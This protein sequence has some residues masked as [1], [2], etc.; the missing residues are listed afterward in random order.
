M[1]YKSICIAG[2]DGT[3]KSSTIDMIVDRLGKENVSIQYMGSRL[4]ETSKAKKYLENEP[5]SGLKKPFWIF[6]RVYAQIK[7]MYHRVRKHNNTS[8]LVVF[9]RYAYEKAVFDRTFASN[10]IQWMVAVV[11]MIFL[12]WFFPAPDY[13]FYLTCPLEVSISR[14]LDINT[15][16][17]INGLRINKDSLDNYYKNKKNVL[18]LDTSINT[19]EMIVSKILEMVTIKL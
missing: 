12:E 17:D 4:W 3:G 15:E 10:T 1:K 19:Q 2:V 7:E 16:E 11:D 8:K 5:P 18:V 9:D 6:M 14:K 13:T